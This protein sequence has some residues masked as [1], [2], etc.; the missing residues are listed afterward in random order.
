M[1]RRRKPILDPEEDASPAITNNTITAPTSTT[2]EPVAA[3][4]PPQPIATTHTPK[5]EAVVVTSN[6]IGSSTGRDE[7]VCTEF[8]KKGTCRYGEYCKFAHIFESGEDIAAKANRNVK[9][10]REWDT[11]AATTVGTSHPCSGFDTFCC[12]CRE[13]PA[14][15]PMAAPTYCQRHIVCTSCSRKI[16]TD[17]CFGCGVVIKDGMLR[18]I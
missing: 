11:A 17:K 5:N 9:R 18:G 16:P 1:S 3:T 6:V 7:G 15:G 14:V 10:W 2:N 13:D 8:K 12:V 4:P